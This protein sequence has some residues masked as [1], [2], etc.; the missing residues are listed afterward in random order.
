MKSFFNSSA[1]DFTISAFS[2]ST[3]KINKK[4]IKITI[5]Y[6]IKLFKSITI[7]INKDWD[8]PNLFHEGNLLFFFFTKLYGK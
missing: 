5:N 2:S 3:L 4:T 6:E 8:I 1:N 7:I